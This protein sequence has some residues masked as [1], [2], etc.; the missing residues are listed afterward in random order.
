MSHGK[1]MRLGSS[2][3]I[4]Y[5]I[6]YFNLFLREFISYFQKH[7]RGYTAMSMSFIINLGT[8]LRDGNMMSTTNER[9]LQKSN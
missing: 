7:P 4:K 8:K 5:L 6:A 2:D 3:E 9:Y 1:T